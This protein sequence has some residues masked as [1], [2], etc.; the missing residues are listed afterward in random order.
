MGWAGCDTN[1]WIISTSH[2]GWKWHDIV[3]AQEPVSPLSSKLV[4]QKDKACEVSLENWNETED[5]I[6]G[7]KKRYHSRNR[8]QGW[9]EMT[10]LNLSETF[11]TTKKWIAQKM[12]E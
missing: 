2:L 6:G 1:E 9:G 4:V 8:I 10:S 7:K 3:K 11:E 5:G 12:V